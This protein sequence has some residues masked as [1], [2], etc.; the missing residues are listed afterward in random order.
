[1]IAC[2]TP[3]GAMIIFSYVAECVN[4]DI[5]V[6]VIERLIQCVEQ[7]IVD[8]RVPGPWTQHLDWLN[9]VLAEVWSGRGVWPGAGSVLQSLGFRRG[10]AYQRE[11]LAPASGSRA[12]TWQETLE[13]LEGRREPASATYRDGLI[14]ARNSWQRLL[15]KR[16]QLLK[17]LARFELEPGQVAR[18][19][20]PSRRLDCG[21]SASD[22]ELT[23]NP[24][25]LFEYDQGT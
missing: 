22:E 4:D 24:Y 25:L 9:D 11:I 2:E 17:C 5:A 18:L 20:D 21:I 8:G 15:D 6:G 16:R 23:E 13:I 19:A 12:G 3:E 7:V 1:M 14:R 10:T